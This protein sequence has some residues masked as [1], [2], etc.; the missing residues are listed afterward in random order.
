[1]TYLEN[2]SIVSWLV[3]N[4]F[5]A[6]RRAQRACGVTGHRPRRLAALACGLER[7]QRNLRADAAVGVDFQKK[8]MSESA[9]DDVRLLDAG[10]EA[11]QAGFDLG[12]HPLVDHLLLNQLLA[13]RH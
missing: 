13:A 8:R 5:Q 4:A 3:I 1:M 10:T 7:S 11:V 6:R 12:D 2:N 9:V